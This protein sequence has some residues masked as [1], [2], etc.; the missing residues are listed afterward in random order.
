LTGPGGVGKTRVSLA[1]AEAVRS[2]PV[3]TGFVDLAAVTEDT[4]VA[5]AVAQALGLREQGSRDALEQIVSAVGDRPLLLVLDNFEHV[6]AAAPLLSTLLSRCPR[7]QLLVTSRSP[8]RIRGERELPIAP[9]AVPPEDHVPHAVHDLLAFPGIR[10]F[11]ERAQAVDPGF[12]L[13]EENAETVAAICRRLDGLPLALELA[14]ARTRVL[15]LPALLFRLTSRFALLTDGPVD[16]PARH[17]TLRAAINWSHD[18]LSDAER[19]AFRRLS[20]F[21]GGFSL[22]AAQAVLAA[23]PALDPEAGDNALQALDALISQSL[24]RRQDAAG[25]TGQPRYTMLETVREFGRERLAANAETSATRA[26]HARWCQDLAAQAAPELV[27]AQQRTWLLRLDAEHANLRLALDWL[28][29]EDDV[30]PALQ[31][32]ADLA[33]FWW[34]RGHYAEGRSRLGALL[35]HPAARENLAAWAAAMDGLGLLVRAQGDTARA[36]EI[37]EQAVSA[38]RALRSRDR[39]ADAL[40]LFG[41]ALMY[42]GE[43]LARPVLTESLAIARTLPQ[44]RWLG[45]TL[46]ALGRTLRYRGELGPA[47]EAIEE[48]LRRAEAVGNPSG[49]AVSLW[50]L[51][52]VLLDLGELDTALDTLQQALRR[53][54][55]LGEVWSAILCLERIA[56]V[57]AQ[58]SVPEAITLVTAA[59]AWRAQVGLPLPAVDAERQARAFAALRARLAQKDT[60]TGTRAGRALTPAQVVAL[61]L[62]AEFP[63]R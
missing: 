20:V 6:Q 13:T 34:Y 42:S 51:G 46:W 60:E 45:G 24:L 47:R 1:V 31:M 63:A 44:P 8:L 56:D 61:A 27:G 3:E 35:A 28:S 4:L 55:D 32:A 11:T 49:I 57:L 33:W 25:A 22:E 5:P 19:A 7:L 48:S 41:L 53:L 50:G 2:L 38:W 18:L 30:G 26:A 23:F 15:P 39:L 58:R 36:V 40:F 37:H 59:A 17:R 54:W 16:A 12:R 14:A 9:L 29:S 62:D 52:E 21:A 10:L 43:P